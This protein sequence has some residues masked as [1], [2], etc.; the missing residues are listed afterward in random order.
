MKLS[1]REIL[2]FAIGCI[3]G[4]VIAIC[5]CLKYVNISSDERAAIYMEGYQAGITAQVE[6]DI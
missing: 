6:D 5:A 4:V 2:I 1:D 3:A